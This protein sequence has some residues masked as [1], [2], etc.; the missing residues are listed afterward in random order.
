VIVNILAGVAIITFMLILN[1]T[2]A[3]GTFNGILFYANIVATNMDTYFFPFQHPNPITVL[4]SWLNL[5]IGFDICVYEG[6]ASGDKVFSQLIFPAYI[7]ILTIIVIVVSECS[8][9]FARIIGKGNPV[10]VL[11]S[12][13][14]LSYTK[15]INSTLGLIFLVYFGPAY[16]SRNGDLSFINRGIELIERSNDFTKVFISFLVAVPMFYFSM[17]SFIMFW[18]HFGSSL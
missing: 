2:V 11:A 5:E 16:G 12:M 10:A 9:K 3:V 4:I 17:V 1:L 14:L 15:F 18:S 13:I 6:M 8:P 7:I